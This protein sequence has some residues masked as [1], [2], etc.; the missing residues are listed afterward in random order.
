MKKTDFLW[1]DTP[2]G[3]IQY[4]VDEPVHKPTGVALVCHPH[5]LF[6]G[7]LENKVTQTLARCF[8]QQGFY[9]IRP[10][11]RGVG[12]SEGIHD[13]GDGEVDDMVVVLDW[14][15]QHAPVDSS[16]RSNLALG[17]FSFGSMVISR[18]LQR[19]D[20]SQILKIVLAG[21]PPSRWEMPTI[22]SHS[23]VIHGEK[24]DVA[25]LGDL[26]QWL[27][28]QHLGV[29]VIPGGDHFFNQKLL[30]LKQYVLQYLRG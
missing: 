29:V 27:E 28:P 6:G 13:N 14:L 5:P 3:K 21:A 30:L 1:I 16:L 8:A 26:L 11:F 18:L 4:V 19:V 10:N 25:P 17:G 9:T 24:D 7:S 23:L 12:L 20:V 2:V 15:A 22:P